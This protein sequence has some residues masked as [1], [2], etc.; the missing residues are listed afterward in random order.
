MFAPPEGVLEAA[1]GLL[2]VT[3]LLAVGAVLL[4]EE[5]EDVVAA[6]VRLPQMMLRHAVIAS[7]SLPLDTTHWS[8]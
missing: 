2:V 8:T 6:M 7:K 3:V 5:V 4:E 1:A